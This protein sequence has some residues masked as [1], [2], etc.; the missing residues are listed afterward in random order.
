[1][2]AYK[3]VLFHTGMSWTNLIRSMSAFTSEGLDPGRMSRNTGGRNEH[4]KLSRRGA[5]VLL[6]S[7]EEGSK[8]IYK[9]SLLAST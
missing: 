3:S 7:P 8:F 2:W 1:M 9:V 5:C 6:I 4:V